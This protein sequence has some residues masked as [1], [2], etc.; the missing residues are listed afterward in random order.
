MLRNDTG[1][2]TMHQKQVSAL[3][4]K[5]HGLGILCPVVVPITTGQSRRPEYRPT[6]R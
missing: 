6:A 1:D 4:N 2:E 3:V 5:Y